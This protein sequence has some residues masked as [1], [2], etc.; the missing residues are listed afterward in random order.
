MFP[1]I[2]LLSKLRF[3]AAPVGDCLHILRTGTI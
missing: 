2:I 1:K 3:H